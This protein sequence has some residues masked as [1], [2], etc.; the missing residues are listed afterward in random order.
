MLDTKSKNNREEERSVT[1]A[2]TIRTPT[3]HNVTHQDHTSDDDSDRSTQTND[4]E[5][6]S[7][8]AT[9][10]SAPSSFFS[11]SSTPP[12]EFEGRLNWRNASDTEMHHH[13]SIG[14]GQTEQ[15]FPR[16][17]PN[18]SAFFENLTRTILLFTIM[19]TFNYASLT[20]SS[21]SLQWMKKKDNPIKSHKIRQSFIFITL[22]ACR[23]N[24]SKIGQ[25]CPI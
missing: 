22:T 8:S 13:P 6:S 11:R 21:Q 25:R 7:S 17:N 1:I 2:I 10:S 23:M 14:E 3:L 12:I 19:H 24:K 5:D 15:I 4:D 18:S 9:H 16:R 20:Q